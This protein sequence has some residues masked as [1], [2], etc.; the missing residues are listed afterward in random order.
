MCLAQCDSIHLTCGCQLCAVLQARIVTDEVSSAAFAPVLA[1][2]V[3]PMTVFQSEQLPPSLADTLREHVEI[4]LIV[5]ALSA[6][7]NE[8]SGV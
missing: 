1:H 6:L 8:R 7:T 3:L 5:D 4:P 2:R